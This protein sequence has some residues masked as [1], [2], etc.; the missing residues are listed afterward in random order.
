MRSFVAVF[1][2]SFDSF[3]LCVVN[4][5]KPRV[6]RVGSDVGGRDLDLES[7]EISFANGANLGGDA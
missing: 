5:H 4:A 2:F 1:E 7:R 6:G 3:C